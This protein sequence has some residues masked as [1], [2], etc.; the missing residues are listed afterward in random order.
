MPVQG[1]ARRSTSTTSAARSC[2]RR[3]PSCPSTTRPGS[4]AQ[5]LDHRAAEIVAAANPT[6]LIELGSGAAAKTRCLLDAMRGRRHARDLRPGRHLRGDHAAGRRRAGRRVRGHP[7]ARRG[8]RLR[9]PSRAGPAR[10]GRPDRLPRRHDRQLP[11]GPAAL[12]PGPDRDPDV[13]R[14]PLPAR[15]R[16]G[17]GHRGAR[18]RL[19]RLGRRHRRVQQERPSRPQPR[20]RRRLRPRAVRARRLLRRRERVDRHP[21]ALARR[22]VHRPAGARH[23]HP[24][25]PQRGDAD[26]DL[27]QVHARAARGQLRRRRAR[28]GRVVD[29]PGRALRAQPRAARV[30]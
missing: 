10:G 27:D 21:P 26:R 29:R 17:Q 28:A 18:G 20:A 4:S 23:A 2:S 1:A 5:I 25:R 13:P 11:P 6:T 24:L 22:A 9:D 7:R 15:H 19:Q 12:V 16:P 8:L 3:S 14:R 30:L